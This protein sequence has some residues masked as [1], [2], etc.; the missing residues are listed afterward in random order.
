M[1]VQTNHTD[2]RLH[3]SICNMA[4][5]KWFQSNKCCKTSTTFGGCLCNYDINHDK[6][7]K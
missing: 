7:S 4:Y 2:T 1:A 6:K 5:V 3:F